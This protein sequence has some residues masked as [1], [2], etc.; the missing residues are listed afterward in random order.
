MRVEYRVLG[1]LEADVDG[2]PA[3]LGA[4][5]QRAALA[6][7]L[8]RPNTVVPAS[9]L[10]DGL[11]GDD[12]PGSAPNLVQ[13][14]VS[15][16]RKAL[17]KEAIHTRGAGY[18]LEVERGALDLERFEEL[19]HQGSRA[20]EEGDPA[21]ASA[22]LGEALSLWRGPALADLQSELLLDPVSGRLEELRVLAL[23][24]RIEADLALGRHEEVVGELE[25]LVF[26]HP[27]RERPRGLL[28]TALY[29]SRRQADALGVYRAARS[30]LVDELGIEP[31]A[32]LTELHAAILR[33]A[34]ELSMGEEP[35]AEAKRCV[36]VA[37]LSPPAAASLAALA[38]PL[39]VEPSRELLVLTTVSSS[40]DLGD[41]SAL[42]HGVRASM[43]AEGVEARAAVFTSVAPGA[44]IARLA[45]EHD[46]DLV[47]VDA[48]DGL[49]ED[50]RVLAL[51]DQAPCDVGVVV[52]GAPGDGPVVVPFAGAEHDWAAVELGAWL[53][54][55]GGTGL[56]LVGATTGADGR[57]ASRLLANASIAVQRA[58][59]VPAEPVLVE[60]E[61]EALVSAARDAGVVV[62]GLTDRW[63]RDGLGRARTA[64]AT[65]A[66]PPTILVRR[67]MRPGGLAPRG[68]E[69]R[70]TWTVAG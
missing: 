13:G 60:P 26:E 51:L 47:L 59:G 5:K 39:T 23:E 37:A 43:V 1:P 3:R 42:L 57:D 68:S 34:P 62:V 15:G 28:M 40:H 41:A 7:L 67:G 61:P 70:F 46:V 64:L 16:L 33:Q 55:C 49:L 44:D 48:P 4:P 32:W 52:D 19:A 21:A 50:A 65:Q 30:A 53:A 14:Y 66:G 17:G 10:V 63:R 22:S 18:L 6:L 2:R 58:L 56:R 69:T 8:F 25:A 45:R 38:A 31:S 54:R 12:P 27:L 24:R 29:R 9:R 20:L 36:L 35:A 11:W